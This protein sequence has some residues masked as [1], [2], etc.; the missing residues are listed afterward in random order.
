MTTPGFS[1]AAAAMASPPV[2]GLAHHLHVRGVQHDPQPEPH[3][4]VVLDEE[5]P[6]RLSPG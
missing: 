3:G 1:S 6:H 5:D 4:G 2:A